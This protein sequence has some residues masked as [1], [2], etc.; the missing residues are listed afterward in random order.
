MQLQ[1]EKLSSMSIKVTAMFKENPKALRTGIF[2][3]LPKKYPIANTIRDSKNHD[4]NTI[5]SLEVNLSPKL[6]YFYLICQTRNRN[7]M[8]RR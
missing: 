2:M 3:K 5:N 1:F 7:I 4:A 6:L 8:P